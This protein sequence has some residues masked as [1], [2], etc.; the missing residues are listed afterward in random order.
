[1]KEKQR[2]RDEPIFKYILGLKLSCVAL[3]KAS[4]GID[5]AANLNSL[6]TLSSWQ[7]QEIQPC[8]LP[9]FR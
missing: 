7:K 4:D 9:C 8:A 2:Y 5:Y 3:T 6:G 1:M